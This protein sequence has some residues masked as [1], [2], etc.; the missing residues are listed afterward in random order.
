[1]KNGADDVVVL[2]SFVLSTSIVFFLLVRYFPS[3]LIHIIS[4]FPFSS[5]LIDCLRAFV[6]F[7]YTPYHSFF[8]AIYF[9]IIWPVKKTLLS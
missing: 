1:M 4:L 7:V 6:L 5:P 3:Q 2:D 9:F 8:F